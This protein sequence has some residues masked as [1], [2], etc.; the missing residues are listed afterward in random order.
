MSIQVAALHTHYAI[1]ACDSSKTNF[2][3]GR[4]DHQTYFA[5]IRVDQRLFARTVCTRTFREWFR[6]ACRVFRWSV[7]DSPA[8]PHTWHFVEP[9]YC[10]PE[11]E[12][13]SIGTEL[14]IG[15][16]SHSAVLTARGQDAKAVHKKA[17]EDLGFDNVPDYLAWVR[18]NIAAKFGGLV[19]TPEPVLEEQKPSESSDQANV[20]AMAQILATA[21]AEQKKAI[22]A[23]ARQALA[24]GQ[25]A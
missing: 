4:L 12:A 10:D 23:W 15:V 5:M 22:A 6:E 7:A 11:A 2:S 19:R 9:E 24:I 25:A 8:P 20:E 17:A 13:N 18:A 1:A 14:A 3:S 16:A 21:S